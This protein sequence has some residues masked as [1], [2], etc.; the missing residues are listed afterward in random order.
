MESKDFVDFLIVIKSAAMLQVGSRNGG[1]IDEVPSIWIFTYSPDYIEAV[2]FTLSCTVRRLILFS[3]TL[4]L[5]LPHHFCFFPFLSL[6]PC[7]SF[8]LEGSIF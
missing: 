2:A 5:T 1:A 7:F 4:L 8:S 6:S 3:F